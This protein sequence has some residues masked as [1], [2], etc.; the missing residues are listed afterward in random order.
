MTARQ[1]L[2]QFLDFPGEILRDPGLLQNAVFQKSQ[3]IK[4]RKSGRNHDHIVVSTAK[5]LLGCF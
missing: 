3:N 4:V 2:F 5:L 1:K